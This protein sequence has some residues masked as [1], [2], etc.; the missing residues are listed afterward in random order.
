M[1]Y[2]LVAGN[3]RAAVEVVRGCLGK[4]FK[5][6]VA[7]SLEACLDLFRKKRYEITF[8]DISL[9]LSPTLPGPRPDFKQQLYPFWK[10]S[11]ATDIIIMTPPERIRDA[12]GAVKAGASD[13]L[14]YPLNPDEVRHVTEE[15]AE[16]LRLRSEL[17]YLRDRFWLKD[18]LEVVKTE[19]PLVRA[20]FDKVRLV[21]PTNTT[22]LL[23]GETGTGKGVI[24]KLIHLHSQRGERQFINVHCGAI[25]E[26]LVESELFGHEKGAF[27]GAVK[28]K[29]GKFEIASGGTIFLDEIGTVSPAVQIK[30]LQ[31]LQE[32]SFQRVGGE[33][34]IEVDVRVIAA[35]NMDLK[36]LCA[37]GSFRLDLFYRLNVFPIEIPPLRKRLEDLAVLVETF[38]KRLN[39][40]SS[41]EIVDVDAQVLE[42]FRRYA[43]PGN[44]RELEN[45]VE[46]AYI[47]ENSSRLTPE[48]FPSELFTFDSLSSPASSDAHL[49]LVE[50]R[51]RGMEQIERRY[52]KELM[53]QNKG[54]VDMTARAAGVS[55]RQMRNLLT[56]Y[57]IHKEE[58]R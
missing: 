24:A 57:G 31:V 54:R 45:L 30:L 52:L 40:L 56:K 46:R 20:V 1:K 33:S 6:D 49:T 27:T 2:I 13:Y 5:V 34:D 9:F 41:K 43:W 14:G 19:S 15:L 48:S 55:S 25:P 38:L 32:R 12:V 7:A 51:Q 47:L 36:S 58:F 3:D 29:L 42:A 16:S 8:I 4:E 23:T 10:H 50:V 21:A 28:R 17:D 37:T 44:I 35:T 22:V 18:S 39:H 53:A 26:T 11:P